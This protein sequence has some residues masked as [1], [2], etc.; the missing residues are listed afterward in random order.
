[1]GHP[2]IQ[3]LAT[4]VFPM[5][6]LFLLLLLSL[7]MLGD[8]AQN[9]ETFGRYYGWLLVLNAL[10]VLFISVLIAFNAMQL[11]RQFRE[12]VA[13]SRLT[14]KLVVMLV[15]VALVPVGIVYSFS[16]NFLRSGID[17]WFNIEIEHAL[18]K[19]IQ[20]SRDSLGLQMRTLQQSTRAVAGELADVSSDEAVIVFSNVD[21]GDSSVEWTLISSDGEILAS[22]AGA[23][24]DVVSH[25][26]GEDMVAAV[27]DNGQYISVDNVGASGYYARVI[28]P[29]LASD[30]TVEN[31]F[32]QGLF[33]LS[34]DLSTLAESVENAYQDYRKLVFLREPLKVSYVLTLSLVL[35]LSALMAVWFAFYSARRLMLP[36]H[37]LVEGTRAVA[38]GDYSTRLPNPGRDELGFL[39]RS[40]NAMTERIS[41]ARDAVQNS[42][43][44]AESQRAYL[45]AVLARISTGVLTVDNKR[46]VRT[47]NEAA[48]A[49]L[50]TSVGSL[51]NSPLDARGAE[52]E[53][54]HQFG[55]TLTPYFD[56]G[57][58][59]WSAEFELFNASGRK[60]I[61]C[62]GAHI[63]EHEGIDSGYVLVFDDVTAMVSAQREAAWSEV[64][65]R[66][67]HEIK[68]PL[69]PIRLSAERMRHK[70]LAR[71]EQAMDKS[72]A[73]MLD[74]ATHTIVQ[75][76][77]SMKSMV[78]AF[79][80]YA[81][82]PAADFHLLSVN[83]LVE[84]IAELYYGHDTTLELDL[85]EHLPPVMA[86]RVRLRQLLHNLVKNAIEAQSRQDTASVRLLTRTIVGP[87]GQ[88]V[89][90]IVQD[91]GPGF[92]GEILERLFEPYITSKP[93]GSGL[94]LAIVKKIV[95]EHGGTVSAGNRESGAR[96]SVRLPVD[97]LQ[98]E[99]P[100]GE[101][102]HSLQQ[103]G[104]T[105]NE[106]PNKGDVA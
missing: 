103:L 96:I 95:E 16:I 3:R 78:N 70:L 34:E 100:R 46:I 104:G 65:R 30:P 44:R 85:D 27:R 14:V 36:I 71:M 9:P 25:L 40:F 22:R 68:N 7:Y 84:E 4:S 42:Q 29:V 20:L 61:V 10:G 17:S 49:I 51:Q 93:K 43:L 88:Y 80:D 52:V 57:G 75:Q 53:L 86:D 91:A 6:A 54:S 90:L 41:R 50:E 28:V 24:G 1:M 13:G 5:L 55:S 63:G 60:M 67:A 79:A 33:P 66:L 62:R 81:N 58:T 69:T 101:P 32:L 39:V 72:E 102:V 77:E 12:R 105:R 97:S 73:E 26:P 99:Q 98:Q 82:A 89:E 76:V 19:A 35:M 15:V 2:V 23:F 45:E 106:M 8:T 59:E 18:D 37:H 48:A 83:S 94:G 38:T 64:A 31:H 87:R 92:P 21:D 11:V 56:R 74:R 47:A